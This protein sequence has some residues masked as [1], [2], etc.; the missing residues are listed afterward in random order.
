MDDLWI[1]AKY[2]WVHELYAASFVSSFSPTLRS[3][4]DLGLLQDHFPSVSIPSYFSAASNTQFLQIVFSV[5]M[6]LS[7]TKDCFLLVRI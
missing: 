5:D 4:Q 1:G 2:T 6:P 7:E 3:V